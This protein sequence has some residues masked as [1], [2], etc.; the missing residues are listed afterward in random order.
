VGYGL[1]W[2]TVPRKLFASCKKFQG[3]TKLFC[4]KQKSLGVRRTFQSKK[5]NLHRQITLVPEAILY[6]PKLASWKIASY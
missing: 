5:V 3:P 2:Q 1:F 4:K 6:K